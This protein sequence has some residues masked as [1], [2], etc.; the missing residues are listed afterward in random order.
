MMGVF[1][2]A[3]QAILSHPAL[4]WPFGSDEETNIHTSALPSVVC[5]AG[6][7]AY[8]DRGYSELVYVN[9]GGRQ[10][11]ALLL[12]E[13]AAGDMKQMLITARAHLLRQNQGE[14]ELEHMAKLRDRLVR[15]LKQL[16]KGSVRAIRDGLLNTE[17]E[18][19]ERKRKLLGHLDAV[20]A[21][22]ASLCLPASLIPDAS[23]SEAYAA[24]LM[25]LNNV[26]Q[27][28]RLLP[29]FC[30]G[31]RL[32]E[33]VAPFDASILESLQAQ[34]GQSGPCDSTLVSIEAEAGEETAVDDDEQPA[35]E[36]DHEALLKRVGEE[37]QVIQD[38]QQ[39]IG[40]KEEDIQARQLWL[41]DTVITLEAA[42]H[43]CPTG[44]LSKHLDEILNEFISWFK[45]L[46]AYEND[47][48][49]VCHTT[50]AEVISRR[51]WIASV[52][53]VLRTLLKL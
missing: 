10:C 4:Q 5:D 42:G 1:R 8:T 50:T 27:S 46:R 16:E 40:E 11:V 39:E 31:N 51:A 49:S 37:V 45:Q 35:E 20:D 2:R 52:K 33:P 21:A 43:E 6:E 25:T 3:M 41:D 22:Q 15:Q 47:S 12:T 24:C 14:A 28:A 29:D 17:Q 26:F 23:H 9:D 48:G 7:V 30:S 44:N 13:D 36:L 32:Q 34:Q 18:I 53:R 19:G 38:L